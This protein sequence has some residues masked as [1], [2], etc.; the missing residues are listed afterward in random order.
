MLQ[1]WN[2][3]IPFRSLRLQFDHQLLNTE[4]C[5]GDTDPTR[6]IHSLQG[7]QKVFSTKNCVRL[8]FDRGDVDLAKGLGLS[9]EEL[10]WLA[11]EIDRWRSP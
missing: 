6:K 5:L 7:L 8:Q 1:L 3:I 9:P 11:Q 10:Q 4:V 2:E